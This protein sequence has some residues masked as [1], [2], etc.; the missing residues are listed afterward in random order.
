MKN[1]IKTSKSGFLKSVLLFSA[2]FVISFTNLAQEV[3]YLDKSE[4]EIQI[5]FGNHPEKY[6]AF[7]GGMS[8]LVS[9]LRENI[10]YPAEA[11]ENKEEGRVV[12]QFWIEID[13]KISNIVVLRG[14][15]PSLDKE[16]VRL[17][18]LMPD[19]IPAENRGK[20]I[21]YKFTLPISFRLDEE[22]PTQR[23]RRR[24][25]F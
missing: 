8:A 20:K 17:V 10:Q 13:G 16:A 5:I 25:I 14:V 11:I 24:W 7:P 22:E 9:F 21:R 18:E 12:I 15:S 23:R 2:I 3:R 19:W 4:E 1:Q 6:P